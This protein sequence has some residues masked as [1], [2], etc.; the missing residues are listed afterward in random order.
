MLMMMM[1]NEKMKR[2][3]RRRKRKTKKQKKKYNDKKPPNDHWVQAKSQL[4][5]IIAK[6]A[7][8]GHLVFATHDTN[9]KN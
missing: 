9:T 7:A 2:R 6:V 3:R 1:R 5:D 8:K 4:H